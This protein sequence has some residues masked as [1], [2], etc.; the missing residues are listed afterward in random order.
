MTAA[1]HRRASFN[2]AVDRGAREC[3]PSPVDFFP[4]S[5]W[6]QP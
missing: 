1:P 6:A 2:A 3:M 4:S 5:L